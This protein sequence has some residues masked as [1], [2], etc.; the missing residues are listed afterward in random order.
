MQICSAE[1]IGGGE[2]HVIDLIRALIERGHD[3]HLVLRP[4]SPLRAAIAG[5]P[6]TFHEL[7]YGK[8]AAVSRLHHQNIT[9]P[10]IAR[11]SMMS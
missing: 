2:W 4:E 5:W 9:L 7:P 8:R 1:T 10:K 11:R 6:V 3:L